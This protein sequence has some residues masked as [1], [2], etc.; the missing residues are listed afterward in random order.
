MSMRSSCVSS[1]LSWRLMSVL[2]PE[3]NRHKERDDCPEADP[4]REFHLRQPPRRGVGGRAEE[5][6]DAVEQV[7]Q[8]RDG[9]EAGDHGDDVA[10]VRA[11]LTREHSAEKNA[12]Q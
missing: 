2:T 8:D 5:R 12:E 1:A 6:G 10:L 9:D 4:P 7:A 11:A 3:A